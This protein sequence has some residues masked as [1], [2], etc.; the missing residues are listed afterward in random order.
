MNHADFKVA[1]D[2]EG[3]EEKENRESFHRDFGNEWGGVERNECL[4]RLNQQSL[5]R[6]ANAKEC[7]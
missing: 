2:A 4:Q 6:N 5:G 7:N 1:D 3:R